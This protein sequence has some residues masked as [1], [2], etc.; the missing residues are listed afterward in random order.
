MFLPILLSKG[1]RI[2]GDTKLLEE[3]RGKETNDSKVNPR[4]SG[5]Y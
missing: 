1:Y 5:G 4:K 3:L 2:I